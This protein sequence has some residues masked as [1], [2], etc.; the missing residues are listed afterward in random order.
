MPNDIN[1]VSFARQNALQFLLPQAHCNEDILRVVLRDLLQERLGV[2]VLQ[3]NQKEGRGK[4]YRQIPAQSI[5]SKKAINFMAVI[6]H[7]NIKRLT[8]EALDLLASF[9]D[10]TRTRSRAAVSENLSSEQNHRLNKVKTFET[11]FRNV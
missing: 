7:D 9:S 4:V 5:G 6:H 1:T 10:G 2:L 11:F 8:K 3:R